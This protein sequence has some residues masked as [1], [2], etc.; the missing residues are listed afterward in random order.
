MERRND[1]IAVL[2][3][4][5]ALGVTGQFFAVDAR[6]APDL[7]HYYAAIPAMWAGDLS[8]ITEVGGL[9]SAMLAGVLT[10]VRSQAAFE[11]VSVGWMAL[12]VLSGWR[13]ARREGAGAGL[14]GLALLCAMPII[15]TIAR[16][17]WIHFPETAALLGGMWA[18]SADPT[19]ERRRTGLALAL[20]VGF[21]MV[22][23]PTG[24]I[25]GLPLL[26]GAAWRA[27]LRKMAVPA[28]GVLLGGAV[29]APGLVE[30]ISGKLDVRTVYAA[31]VAPLSVSLLQATFLTPAALAGV[32]L[33]V[34]LRTLE[35]VAAVLWIWM[36]LGIIG[37][38]F[39]HVGVDNFPLMFVSL[40]LLA[41]PGL[42]RLSAWSRG[43]V[44]GLAAAVA[45][46][47]MISPL[48]QPQRVE[49][50]IPWLGPSITSFQPRDYLRPQG[51]AL[52]VAG[53][54]SMLAE[55]CP[56]HDGTCTVLTPTGI[57]NHNREDDAALALFLAGVDDV[58]FHNAGQWWLPESLTA[59]DAVEGV[60]VMECADI[61]Q[62][63]NA[64]A[65]R[66]AAVVA[67]TRAV[68]VV[69][70]G[71][72]G[73]PAICPMRWYRLDARDSR[74]AIMHFAREHEWRHH[75][76]PDFVFRRD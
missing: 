24:L 16:C 15:H 68:P 59:T 61:A 19:L 60:V 28:L 64:F 63:E 6:P 12:L 48:L 55:V 72:L 26:A 46:A 11:A 34:R 74:G 5:V 76:L 10:V 70:V 33:L 66:E 50:L 42:A 17:H 20:A 58:D 71:M 22:T 69:E 9:Y 4:V 7:G 35:P 18:W 27:P 51:R 73:P 54:A 14:A 41:A 36:L 13:I 65:E 8:G 1:I 21:V 38:G 75:V 3:I 44:G 52:T 25:F 31:T 30:Y 45:V 67:L 49:P 2:L 62:G 57:F 37:S 40:A 32:G 39:F 23:R 47:A 56:T 29:L 53:L 43:A